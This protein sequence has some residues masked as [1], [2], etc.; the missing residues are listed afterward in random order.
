MVWEAQVEKTFKMTRTHFLTIFDQIFALKIPKSVQNSQ[1]E[2]LS[3]LICSKIIFKTKW[4]DTHV[5]KYRSWYLCPKIPKLNFFFFLTLNLNNLKNK[6]A[7]FIF[8]IEFY[9]NGIHLL[10]SI[11]V[12]DLWT[13]FLEISVVKVDI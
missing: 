5:K 7:R 11:K 4:L 8:S 12:I 13:L 9:K 1:M 6:S 2:R 3:Q 10:Q